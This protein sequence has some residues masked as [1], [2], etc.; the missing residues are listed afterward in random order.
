MNDRVVLE[1]QF[2]MKTSILFFLAFFYINFSLQAQTVN[3]IPLKDIEEEYLQITPK[4]IKAT[5]REV[6]LLIDF[7]Q[8]TKRLRDTEQLL[9]DSAGNKMVFNS[10]IEALNFLYKNGYE[11]IE[12]YR[13]DSFMMRKRK[14]Y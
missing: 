3:G 5:S 7:G 6:Q 1:K 10:E 8:E 14:K 2:K 13:T 4:D 11:L 12:V 9:L